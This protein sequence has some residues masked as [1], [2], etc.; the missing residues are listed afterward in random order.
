MI[1]AHFGCLSALVFILLAHLSGIGYGQ[2][3]GE[4]SPLNS[5]SDCAGVRLLQMR[6]WPGKGVE[7]ILGLDQPSAGSPEIR[8]EKDGKRIPHAVSKIELDPEQLKVFLVV[9]EPEQPLRGRLIR[10]TLVHLM[11]RLPAQC[12]IALYARSAGL[13]QLVGLTRDRTRLRTVLQNEQYW[14]HTRSQENSKSRV[15]YQTAV[16]ILGLDITRFMETGSIAPGAVVWAGL[17]DEDGQTDSAAVS[18]LPMFFLTGRDI[19]QQGK[20]AVVDRLLDTMMARSR[21]VIRI[22]AC[23]GGLPTQPFSLSVGE[24]GGGCR[25]K[26]PLW[27]VEENRLLCRPEQIA[28]GKRRYPERIQFSFSQDQRRVFDQRR[29]AESAKPF[30]LSVGIG[31]ARLVRATAHLRGRSSLHCGRKNFMVNLAGRQARYLLPGAADDRFYLISMC[32]DDRYYQQYTANQLAADLGLFP[33]AFRF[34]ELVVN[35]KSWGIYLLLEH[36]LRALQGE[37]ARVSSIVRR[38]F[39]PFKIPPTIK[40][41]QG[42]SI[43]DPALETYGELMRPPKSLRGGELIDW[44]EQRID[45]DQFL[46]LVALHT[47]LKNGDWVDEVWFY[48]DEVM[49][50]GKQDQYYHVMAW[51]MDDL[52]HRCHLGGKYIWKD[53]FGLTH[54][55]EGRFEKR[56][57]ADGQIFSRYVD[58]LADL[59]SR[60]RANDSVREALGKTWADLQPFLEQPQIIEAMEELNREDDFLRLTEATKDIR[61]HMDRF[62]RAIEARRELLIGR[63]ERYRK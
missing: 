12:E 1:R 4:I 20:G 36:P 11:E 28:S 10:E 39:D 46:R 42:G 32:M 7:I 19:Q 2:T 58:I 35:E 59:L 37:Y 22:G 60:F 43:D 13:C 21:N 5:P 57:L 53:P 30:P 24:E 49:R 18:G 34:V 14:S 9:D 61:T 23:P 41:P 33:L 63:I 54:C 27:P 50:E 26:S 55:I 25:L 44:I 17:S 16:K 47:L 40:V 56:I 52:D 45:L 29:D 15:T 62:A 31:D 38:R 8:L 51:D 3:E 6:G 48:G